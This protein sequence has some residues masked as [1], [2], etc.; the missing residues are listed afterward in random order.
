MAQR[1]RQTWSG[2]GYSVQRGEQRIAPAQ[3]VRAQCTARS[4]MALLAAFAVSQATLPF[5]AAALGIPFM[6]ALLLLEKPA[7]PALLGCALGL[8]ARWRP[9]TL[10]N[11][12]P[13]AACVLLVLTV[14]G[15]WDWK[16]WKVSAAAAACMALPLPLA[17]RS[18]RLLAAFFAGIAA[19]GVATPVFARALLSVNLKDQTLS[20]DDRLC[21]MLFAAAVCMGLEWI[22]VRG[23]SLGAAAVALC[24]MAAGACA[25]PG[26]AAPAGVLMGI[27]QAMAGGETWGALFFCALGALSG[28]LRG[29][30]RWMIA[31]GSALGV[32]IAALALSGLEGA[33]VYAPPVAAAA[34]AFA[35]VPETWLDA[36][37]GL[38]QPKPQFLSGGAS[39]AVSHLLRERATA[40]SEMAQ[41]LPAES[42]EKDEPPLELLACRL[43]TGCERQREC[44]DARREETIRLL[45]GA[46]DAFALK[47]KPA[48]R[49]QI[50]RTARAFGCLR[51]GEAPELAAA[52]A[53]ERMGGER[54]RR[55]RAESRAWLAEQLQAQARTL[56]SACD[57]MENEDGTALRAREAVLSAMPALRG[58]PDALSVCV[59]EGRLHVWLNAACENEGRLAKMESALSAAVGV[60]M[61][62]LRSG[63]DW[64]LFSETPALRM[65]TARACATAAGE[66]V[67]GDGAAWERLSAGQYLLALSDGMGSGGEAGRESR[68]ALELL[69]R[70]LRAGY[71]RHDALRWV[72]GMLTACRG[73]GEMFA[74]M[75]LC[76]VDLDSGE[77]AFEKLGACTS[78]LLRGGRCRR[79]GGDALPMGIVGAAS[80]Q[81]TTVRLRPDDWIVMVTD[82]VTDAF[83]GDDG[84]FLR[85]LGGMT[86]RDAAL[87]PQTL[88]DTL[89]R[90]ALERC[91]GA[92]PDDM[93]VLAARV[94][95]TAQR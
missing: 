29:G 80:P 6:A 73:E 61:E 67:S 69:V 95:E 26:V 47:E 90:R 38:L 39:S 22:R 62:L 7:A 83:G 75:D 53:A 34:L 14:R 15:E 54:D 93:T 13:L 58:R 27:M 48:A 30:A 40:L 64:L 86:P 4:G 92:A 20:A 3:W 24:V 56:I 84:A 10:L 33:A 23:C 82:G 17:V 50:D 42:P 87:T 76:T 85:A 44:W 88:A 66:R 63:G 37:R 94:M 59:L 18:P 28:L 68:A 52:L 91:G 72:N 31:A 1:F 43:C 74:T 36:L 2:I 25:G 35:C 77:A 65:E 8:L 46:L 57:Q 79:V 49:E 60:R 55:Q 16:P 9:I 12:W 21:L 71:S 41:T 45:S 51:A 32:T 89:L 70:A 78:Y 81:R 19:A 11:G 5:G